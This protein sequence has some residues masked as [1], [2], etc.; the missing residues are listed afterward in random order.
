MGGLDLADISVIA[1]IIPVV[2]GILFGVSD[3][4]NVWAWVGIF[5][6]GLALAHLA[7]H[8]VLGG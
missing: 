8:K 6:P 1:V 3:L 4:F 7:M 2:F 5:H